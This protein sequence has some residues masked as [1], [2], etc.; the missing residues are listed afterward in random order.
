MIYTG[1]HLPPLDINLYN[2]FMNKS[3]VSISD[4]FPIK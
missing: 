3:L 2:V 1:S 4:D